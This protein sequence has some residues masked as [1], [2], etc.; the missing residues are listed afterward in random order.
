MPGRAAHRPQAL[1]IGNGGGPGEHGRDDDAA[2]DDQHGRDHRGDGGRHEP[3][4]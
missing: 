4:G 2:A 1:A 3:T